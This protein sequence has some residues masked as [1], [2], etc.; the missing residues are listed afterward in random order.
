MAHAGVNRDTYIRHQSVAAAL[1]LLIVG[2]SAAS[3]D[4]D[5]IAELRDQT[6]FASA[7][8]VE[9]GRSPIVTYE[10]VEEEWRR[11][12]AAHAAALTQ[13]P[14]RAPNCEHGFS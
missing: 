11:T 3:Y 4:E 1:W 9:V 13:L 7:Y 8:E 14:N 6:Q 10:L 12:R 2:C 5:Q